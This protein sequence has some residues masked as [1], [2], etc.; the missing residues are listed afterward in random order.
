MGIAKRKDFRRNR[1]IKERGNGGTFPNSIVRCPS[2][3]TIDPVSGC[4]KAGMGYEKINGRHPNLKK[5]HL[6][7][8]AKMINEIRLLICELMLG[9]IIRV[10][11]KDEPAGIIMVGLIKDYA[12]KIIQTKLIKVGIN[13]QN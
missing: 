8:R 10:A 6:K 2:R 13:G 11:P 3:G 12:K 4:R 5:R 1:P 7:K 9:V